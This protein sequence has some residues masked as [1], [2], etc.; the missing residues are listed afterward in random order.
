M[1]NFD[2][3]FW[4]KLNVSKLLQAK[5]LLKIYGTAEIGFQRPIHSIFT[6]F[7][8]L[9]IIKIYILGIK[10]ITKYIYLGWFGIP[11]GARQY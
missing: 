6:D 5:I 11:Q 8:F 10:K 3:S 1:E 9:Y 2:S 4:L 7:K